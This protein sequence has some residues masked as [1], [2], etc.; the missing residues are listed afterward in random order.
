M[1]DICKNFDCLNSSVRLTI[2]GNNAILSNLSNGKW[3]K[4]RKEN[5]NLFN[6]PNKEG[7]LQNCISSGFQHD[8]AKDFID[9][10]VSNN[11]FV[12]GDNLNF[13]KEKSPFE[14]QSAYIHVTNFCNL[15][16]R[17]CY[18]DSHLKSEHGVD[19]D[20]MFIIIDRLKASGIKF[21]VIAGGEPL[22]RYD[23][24]DLLKYISSKKFDGV[25]LLTNG[26]A[27][28]DKLAKLIADCV[29]STHVSLDGPNEEINV[30]IR[31]EGNFEKTINGIRKLKSAGVEKIKIISSITSVNIDHLNEM[32]KL[33]DEI[34][35]DFGTSIF[36]EI[37]RGIEY[38]YLRPKIEDLIAYFENKTS[39]LDC[40]PL[41]TD[42]SLLD[43]NA[44]VTCG[45]GTL[46]I[47]VDCFGD[48]FPCHLLHQPKLKIGN[49]IKQDN[50]LEIIRKSS[51]IKQMQERVVENRKC[52]G[53]SVEYF[54]KGGCLAHTVSANKQSENPWL[55]KDPFCEVHNRILSLQIWED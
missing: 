6:A 53:C 44:G 55:E 21:L 38:S 34:G 28:T 19:T 8:E 9:A 14:L 4:L 29:D 36:A 3:F 1:N 11:F 24:E 2:D 26:T 16:C 43:V 47:S 30:Q 7:V 33:R 22:V 32:S 35:V 12:S 42:S 15:T 10:L 25:T 18:R 49:I 23:I 27:V 50:L 52:H 13:E 51:V 41:A 46:M 48:I 45:A 40:N 5:I 31:G 17:H 37:G 20:S 54:C 39:S